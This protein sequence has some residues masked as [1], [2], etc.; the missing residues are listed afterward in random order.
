MALILFYRLILPLQLTISFIVLSI[1]A[2]GACN[3][4]WHPAYPIGT[5]PATLSEVSGL[6]ASMKYPGRL[7]MVNDSPG[8]E[9]LHILNMNSEI[10]ETYKIDQ[11]PGFDVEDLSIGPCDKN[12]NGKNDSCLFVPDIGD[13]HHRRPFI[14]IAVIAEK[15][16]FENPIVP[17]TIIN[18][19]YPKLARHDA[20]AIG[21]HPK[22]GDIFILTKESEYYYKAK[23]AKLFKLTYDQ[24]HNQKNQPQTLIPLQEL[25]IP[26]ITGSDWYEGTVTGMAISPDG[27][28]FL[29]ITYSNIIEFNYDLSKFPIFNKSTPIEIDN[30]DYHVPEIR[31]LLRQEVISYLPPDGSSF[32]YTTEVAPL[33]NDANVIENAGI[34]IAENTLRENADTEAPLIMR[35]NCKKS[36]KR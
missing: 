27:T 23:A 34:A 32:L 22:T 30:L 18:L 10:P 2:H 7:Y 35:V 20:E 14:Q 17:K 26:I 25:P 9:Y 16:I 15:Q 21:V 31:T 11:F 6:A 5:L 24:W 8:G 19:V 12:E 29:V 36:E 1:P 13:N 3:G 33:P 28:R 4:E